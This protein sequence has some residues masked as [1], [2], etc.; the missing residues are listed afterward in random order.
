[1]HD[2]VTMHSPVESVSLC[3]CLGANLYFFV[4]VWLRIVASLCSPAALVLAFLPSLL[5]IS[6]S[7]HR[8]NVLSHLIKRLDDNDPASRKFACFAIGNA[9]FHSSA[10]FPS[11]FEKKRGN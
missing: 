9:S 2:R 3:V 6:L 8:Y 10:T 5:L 11:S 4:S 7:W 1:M